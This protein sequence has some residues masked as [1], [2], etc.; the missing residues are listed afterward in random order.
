[1]KD[2]FAESCFDP[3]CAEYPTIVVPIGA[4]TDLLSVPHAPDVV[5]R[6]REAMLAGSRFPP[7]SVIRLG[8]RLLLADGNKRLRAYRALAPTTIVVEVWTLRRWLTDQARQLRRNAEKNATILKQGARDPAGA[9]R[10]FGTTTAHWSR[11]VR[12]LF[13]RSRSRS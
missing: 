12:S 13:R 11:V 3:A 4:I 2:V 9:L 8:R 10:L 7:V 5:S 1:V 6:Y